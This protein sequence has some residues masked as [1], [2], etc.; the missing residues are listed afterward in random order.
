MEQKSLSEMEALASA[1]TEGPWRIGSSEMISDYDEFTISSSSEKVDVV[2]GDYSTQIGRQ[3]ASRNT[4]F[5]AAARTFIPD[6]IAHIRALEAQL[7][8][9]PGSPAAGEAEEVPSA[10]TLLTWCL[11]Y[12]DTEGLEY[13][14]D[15]LQRRCPLGKQQAKTLAARPATGEADKWVA[16]GAGPKPH[17]E[18]YSLHILMPGNEVWTGRYFNASEAEHTDEDSTAGWFYWSENDV[19]ERCNPQPTHYHPLPTP[20]VTPTTAAQKGGGGE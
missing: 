14:Y 8:A 16:A 18:D 6:A 15:K 3:Q 11:R 7:A 19:Y 4:A 10:S 13:V 9:R 12:L 5:I 17:E 20:P 2:I 1:A